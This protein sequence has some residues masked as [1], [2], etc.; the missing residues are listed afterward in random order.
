VSE[1]SRRQAIRT[2]LVRAGHLVVA[3][4]ASPFAGRGVSD[5][6]LCL[7]PTGRFCAIECKDDEG[8]PTV[9]QEAFLESVRTRGGAAFVA[10][11]VEDAMGGV[12]RALSEPPER[13]YFT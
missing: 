3:Y 1:K 7:A 5:L 13:R 12:A 6:L 2:A 9:M 4:P 10:R 8:K 11:T